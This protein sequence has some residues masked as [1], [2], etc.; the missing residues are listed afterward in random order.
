M[1]EATYTNVSVCTCM[2]GMEGEQGNARGKQKIIMYINDSK[3][4]VLSE[5]RQ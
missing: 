5:Q 2:G 4:I 1:F 3:N